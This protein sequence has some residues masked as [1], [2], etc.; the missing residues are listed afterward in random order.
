MCTLFPVSRSS[1]Y[2]GYPKISSTI[3]DDLGPA[4]DFIRRAQLVE[5][6]TGKH[7]KAIPIAADEFT[8]KGCII[9]NFTPGI[10]F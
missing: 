7:L 8:L 5:D 6:L 2:L 3:N 9:D 1:E 10:N 4:I